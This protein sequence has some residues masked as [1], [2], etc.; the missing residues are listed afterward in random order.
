MKSIEFIKNKLGLLHHIFSDIKIRYE[1]KANTQSHIIEVVPSSFFEKNEEYM[2]YESDFEEE[3]E[4]SF[5]DENILFISEE[6]LTEINETILEL[7]Y[8]NFKIEISS[9]DDTISVNGYS[10]DTIEIMNESFNYA[11]AA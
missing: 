6:S 11:L 4:N 3:F 2:S 8:N 1:Y 10:N 9:F 7:G 5:P